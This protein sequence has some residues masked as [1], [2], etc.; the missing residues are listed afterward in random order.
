[1]EWEREKKG[2]GREGEREREREM[3]GKEVGEKGK[4]WYN[5]GGRR[6]GM[7]RTEKGRGA[8]GSKLR[9]VFFFFCW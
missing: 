3:G 8:K 6:S 4:R 1:M 2:Q 7:E 9:I 5:V